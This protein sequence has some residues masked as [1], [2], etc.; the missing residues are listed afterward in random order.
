MK[1][2]LLLLLA[3]MLCCTTIASADNFVTYATRAQQNA[4]K[5]TLYD[6]PASSVTVI[7][8]KIALK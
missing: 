3:G 2:T 4:T 5:E 1:K 7:R 8:G 6:L